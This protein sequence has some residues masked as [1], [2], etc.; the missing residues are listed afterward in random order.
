MNNRLIAA[1]PSDNP[2]I[3]A[4]RVLTAGATGLREAF[5]NPQDLMAVVNA[6]MV[7]LK[8]AWI[9]SAVLSGAAF[10]VAFAAEWKSIK[11]DNIKARAAAKATAEVPST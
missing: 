3:S 2:A 10:L 6:Y 1:L 5:P 8:D 9:W 7:G 4:A 11:P